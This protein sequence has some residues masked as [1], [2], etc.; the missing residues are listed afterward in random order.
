MNNT[1]IEVPLISS[2]LILACCTLHHYENVFLRRLTVIS[3]VKYDMVI[4][5]LPPLFLHGG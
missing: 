5:D 4:T 2:G 1:T 3:G